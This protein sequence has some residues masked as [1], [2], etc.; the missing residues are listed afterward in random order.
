[1]AIAHLTA[2]LRYYEINC[3]EE[4]VTWSSY[5]QLFQF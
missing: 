3:W 5:E 4:L 1:M 2:G